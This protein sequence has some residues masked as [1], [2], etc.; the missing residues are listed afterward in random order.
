MSEEDQKLIYDEYK[1]D[2]HKFDYRNFLK[3]LQE[4]HFKTED[5]YNDPNQL[6]QKQTPV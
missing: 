4:F 2:Q 5:V 3:D 6:K 1:L